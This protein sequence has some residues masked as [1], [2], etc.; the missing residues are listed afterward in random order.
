[1]SI[2]SNKKCYDIM[3]YYVLMFLALECY[4]FKTA[5]FDNIIIAG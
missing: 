5:A 1:M 4:L 2:G 3:K